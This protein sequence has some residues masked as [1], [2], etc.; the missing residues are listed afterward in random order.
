MCHQVTIRIQPS[1]EWNSDSACKCSLKSVEV[2][3]TDWTTLARNLG[4][5]RLHTNIV[6]EELREENYADAML[7]QLSVAWTNIYVNARPNVLIIVTNP[8]LGDK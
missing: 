8:Q 2:P 7:E 5:L 4:S 3:L 1:N 6:V